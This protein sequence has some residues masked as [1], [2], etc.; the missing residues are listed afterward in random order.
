MFYQ[1]KKV[2]PFEAYSHDDDIFV[3][4]AVAQPGIV[5]NNR[6]TDGEGRILQR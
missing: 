5:G 3:I 2:P 6:I 1:K 4:R